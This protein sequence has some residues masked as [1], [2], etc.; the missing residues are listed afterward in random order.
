MII[1][2]TG[3]FSFDRLSI[4]AL[5]PLLLPLLMLSDCAVRD[6][7]DHYLKQWEGI[8]FMESI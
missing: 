7:G 8:N 2:N 3:I 6:Y 5:N 4:F 1:K